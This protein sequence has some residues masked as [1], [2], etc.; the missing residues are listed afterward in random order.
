L[1]ILRIKKNTHTHKCIA[2]IVPDECCLSILV[3]LLIYK[4]YIIPS[5][6]HLHMYCR[7]NAEFKCLSWWHIP[8]FFKRLWK[9]NWK[10]RYSAYFHAMEVDDKD[11]EKHVFLLSGILNFVSGVCCL[12]LSNYVYDGHF[13][14]YNTY[15]NKSSFSS[16]ET[17]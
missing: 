2:L 11:H 14:M 8:V 7:Q 15:S 6:A 4:T 3:G 17:S 1:L 9:M 13:N 5:V 10:S 16:L 12:L